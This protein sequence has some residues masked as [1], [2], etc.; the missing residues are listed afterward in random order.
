MVN[1]L[2]Q[3]TLNNV[4]VIS[5]DS[6]PIN[7]TGIEAGKGSYICASDGS[8]MFYKYGIL[9]TQWIKLDV[10]LFGS[11][12]LDFPNLNPNSFADLTI[13]IV[14]ASV[15]DCVSL[16]IPVSSLVGLVIFNSFVSAAD[17]VTVRAYNLDGAQINPPSGL[18][19]V[20]VSKSI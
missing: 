19:K 9:D 11:A 5:T 8:G 12:T 18:F 7:F 15:G 10:V 20:V 14:G 2:G 13:S 6:S 1:I 3:T 4:L 17:T 16:G